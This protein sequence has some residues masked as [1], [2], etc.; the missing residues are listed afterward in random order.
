MLRLSSS[1]A[2]LEREGD[3]EEAPPERR[4]EV[5]VGGRCETQ[6]CTSS[7]TCGFVMRLAIFFEAGLVVITMTGSVGEYG[8]E[9][10]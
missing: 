3:T 10:R 4:L 2:R 9:G 7:D 5:V 8:E 6:S 1:E